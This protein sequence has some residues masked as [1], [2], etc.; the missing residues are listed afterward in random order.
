VW[1]W[2]RESNRR[3]QT[4]SIGIKTFLVKPTLPSELAIVM[5]TLLNT[6]ADTCAA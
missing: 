3:G 2:I 5:R 4:R 1:G 6:A